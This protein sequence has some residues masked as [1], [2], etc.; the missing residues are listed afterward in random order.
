MTDYVDNATETWYTTDVSVGAGDGT[1]FANRQAIPTDIEDYTLISP[2]TDGTVWPIVYIVRETSNG[3][4]IFSVGNP[5]VDNFIAHGDFI[6]VTN[7]AKDDDPAVLFTFDIGGTSGTKGNSIRLAGNSRLTRSNIGNDGTLATTDST[8]LF[9][10]AAPGGNET[11][12]H[13]T[14]CVVGNKVNTQVFILAK[15]ILQDCTIFNGGNFWMSA[16]AAVDLEL[17]GC[18][19]NGIFIGDSS[20]SFAGFL[21]NN[22]LPAGSFSRVSDNSMLHRYRKIDYT[23]KNSSGDTL[24]SIEIY[25]TDGG[26][27]QAKQYLTDS[28]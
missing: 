9:Y 19:A 25:A 22:T 27:R 17:I 23:V 28:S 6:T 2:N 12:I 14:N 3:G 5:G 8:I 26:R 21:Y 18:T 1:S 4:F 20:V 15:A 10:V 11:Q 13:L 24:S 16:S 7:A